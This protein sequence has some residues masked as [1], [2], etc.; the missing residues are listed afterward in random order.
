MTTPGLAK[1]LPY[2]LFHLFFAATDKSSAF[3]LTRREMTN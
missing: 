1:E 3:S 2:Y